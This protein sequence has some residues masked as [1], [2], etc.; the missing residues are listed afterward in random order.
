MLEDNK[1]VYDLFLSLKNSSIPKFPLDGSD[2][3]KLG[4]VGKRLGKLIKNLKDKWIESDFA[5]NKEQLINM[6][7]N[8]EI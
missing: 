6:V 2:L 8:S 7:K 3:I 4:Y 5:L 1:V